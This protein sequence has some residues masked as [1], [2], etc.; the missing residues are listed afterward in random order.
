MKDLILKHISIS[1]KKLLLA[2]DFDGTLSEYIYP[3]PGIGNKVYIDFSKLLFPKIN[4]KNTKISTIEIV[5]YWKSL[6][7]QLI[8]WTCRED[9]LFNNTNSLTDAVNWC[10]SEGL[11]FDYINENHKNA[12][13]GRKIIAD[14]Y[15]DD[16]SCD[17]YDINNWNMNT[18][19][20][21]D[22]SCLEVYINKY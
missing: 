21:T 12:N 19:N 1:N 14:R 15:I 20:I 6:G 5:K 13:D 10:K 18:W 2:I 22:P 4:I 11:E 7:H 3:D 17:I 9:K 16:K 8:L